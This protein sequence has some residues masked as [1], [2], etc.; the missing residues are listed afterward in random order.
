MTQLMMIAAALSALAASAEISITG[1]TAR[2]RWPWNGLV[3]IDYTVGGN[4]NLLAELKARI[5]LA[6]PDGRSWVATKFLPGAEPSVE[7]GRHRATWDTKADGVTNAVAD[8]VV[9]TVEL[10]QQPHP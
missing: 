5:S 3:D 8:G 7:P 2:Q 6:A 10:V 4:K 9:A 1:I